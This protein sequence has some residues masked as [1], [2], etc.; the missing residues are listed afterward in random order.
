MYDDAFQRDQHSDGVLILG[1]ESKMLALMM[2][3]IFDGR[4]GSTLEVTRPLDRGQL[5]TQKEKDEKQYRGN[6]RFILN[7][8]NVALNK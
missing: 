3:R 7:Q 4:K 2:L 8:G 1:Q 5:T 6:Q